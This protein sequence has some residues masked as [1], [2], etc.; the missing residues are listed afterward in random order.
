MRWH[1]SLGEANAEL[2]KM[3]IKKYVPRQYFDGVFYNTVGIILST[4]TI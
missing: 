4:T 3:K 2:K 1:G